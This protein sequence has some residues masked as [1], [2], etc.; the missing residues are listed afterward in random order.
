MKNCYFFNKNG[1]FSSPFSLSLEF[2][3]FW[4][5]GQ[6]SDHKS[7][8]L[9]LLLVKINKSGIKKRKKFKNWFPILQVGMKYVTEIDLSKIE[10]FLGNLIYS[11][12]FGS[13]FGPETLNTIWFS[14]T[15]TKHVCQLNFRQIIQFLGNVQSCDYFASEIGPNCF[16][17]KLKNS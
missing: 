14:K 17:N 12:R 8:F 4:R 5:I 15:F 3:P 10:K 11:T 1:S 2:W 7:G 13:K 6:N 9:H 16:Q